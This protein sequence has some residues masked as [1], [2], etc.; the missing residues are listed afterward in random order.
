MVPGHDVHFTCIIFK[1]LLLYI[2]YY[3]D[4]SSVVLIA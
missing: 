2:V 1:E 3:N 4:V